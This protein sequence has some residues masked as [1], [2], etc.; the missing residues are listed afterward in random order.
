[1]FWLIYSRFLTIHLQNVEIMPKIRLRS[2]SFP[3]LSTCNLLMI[4]F[5]IMVVGVTESVVKHTM[6]LKDPITRLVYISVII[7]YCGTDKNRKPLKWQ[8][9][10]K[11]ISNFALFQEGWTENWLIQP[12]FLYCVH[13]NVMELP[14]LYLW[15]FCVALIELLVCNS[16]KTA[17]HFI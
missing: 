15:Y 16:I 6:Q 5:V 1:M 9:N 4:L 12:I 11:Y 3:S 13:I 2:P 7:T 8:Q 17:T 14:L 10:M